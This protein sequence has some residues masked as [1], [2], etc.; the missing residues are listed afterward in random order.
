V[1]YPV[2]VKPTA[3][4]GS[5]NTF[6]VESEERLREVLSWE[7]AGNRQP[8]MM[9][10]FVVGDE[11]S[12]DSV[13]L[14]GRLVWSSINHYFPSPL[15]VLEK[16]WIQWCVLLPREVH[17]PEYG[18]IR[19]VAERALV[20]L[21]M[22]AG[23]SHMEWFRRADG[24]VAISEVGARPPGAQFTTLISYAHDTDLYRAWAK[25]MVYDD[26]TPPE[27]P[28]AAGAAF[29]RAQGS[30]RIQ[31]IH[32]LDEVRAAIGDVMMEAKLPRRGTTPSGAYDGDGHVI[33]RHPN[34]EVVK[35]AL[36]MIVSKIRV[37]LG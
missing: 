16:P 13:F 10:E 4:S 32:G 19:D 7:S 24:S 34:T 6:R 17:R 29:L 12:F 22:D 9:E 18:N 30:G 5:R 20:A 8:T 31:A 27:R 25:L 23:L 28:Y 35:K 26:F 3:G 33:V 15:E 11:F 1:G 14:G 21:G 36:S 2:I 37:E